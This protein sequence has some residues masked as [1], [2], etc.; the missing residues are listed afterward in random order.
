MTRQREETRAV[1]SSFASALRKCAEEMLRFEAAGKPLKRFFIGASANSRMPTEPRSEFRVERPTWP[2]S[3]TTCRRI[4]ARRSSKLPALPRW[5][6]IGGRVACSNGPVARSTQTQTDALRV[7]PCANESNQQFSA[8]R[9]PRSSSRRLAA[10]AL[11]TSVRKISGNA[12][13]RGNREQT[14][15]S[16]TVRLKMG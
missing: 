14:Q 3:T 5:T 2:F 9:S 15:I 4:S 13:R 7:V 8:A 16:T 6:T 12:L 10:A 1:P 11:R